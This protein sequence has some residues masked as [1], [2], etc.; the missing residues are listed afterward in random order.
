MP[1]CKI[2]AFVL[3]QK[4][5]AVLALH[6]VQIKILSISKLNINHLCTRDV[7]YFRG[8]GGWSRCSYLLATP[9]GPHL[10]LLVFLDKKSPRYDVNVKS[11]SWGEASQ[12]ANLS[13]TNTEH[14]SCDHCAQSQCSGAI[15]LRHN[16]SLLALRFSSKG[17]LDFVIDI[18]HRLLNAYAKKDGCWEN[19]KDFSLCPN[20]PCL[21][22]FF[23][24][25]TRKSLF[26]CSSTQATLAVI[27]LPRLWTVP[28]PT[29]Y[30]PA[31]TP[32][33]KNT[34]RLLG[35]VK[36]SWWEHWCGLALTY[37]P[38]H[39]LYVRGPTI[40]PCPCRKHRCHALLC[41]TVAISS[42]ITAL[43]LKPT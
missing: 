19:A 24:R 36:E 38:A 23:F 1:Q 25:N 14:A 8:T 18:W 43:V 41:R 32:L 42:M 22:L 40:V 39:D 26:R 29:L 28:Y 35:V 16:L 34:A 6:P 37:V 12:L 21:F 17:R 7:E 5:F 10:Y 31:A 11:Q 13:F 2:C 33:T 30:R 9:Y 4:V 3:H 27:S 15:P 20:D